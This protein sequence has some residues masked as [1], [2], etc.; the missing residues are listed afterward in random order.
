MKQSGNSSKPAAKSKAKAKPKPAEKTKAPS[1]AKATKAAKSAPKAAKAA[2][3]P[4]PEIAADPAAKAEPLKS[5]LTIPKTPASEKHGRKVPASEKKAALSAEKSAELNKGITKRDYDRF[6]KMLLIERERVLN[7]V[8]GLE[9]N[10]LREASHNAGS[11]FNELA[12]VGTDNYERE[13]ALRVASGEAELLYE[14]DEALK[15]IQDGTY[16]VCEGTGKPIPKRRLEVFPAARYT[17]EYQAQ[18]E[19]EANNGYSR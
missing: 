7:A 4:A 16:G 5:H 19:R 12:E 8:Q 11:D 18:V 13:V 10:S 9:R 2:V 1:A 3:K 14:I 6:H 17:V 15:R